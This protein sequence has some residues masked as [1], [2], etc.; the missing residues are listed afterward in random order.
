[1]DNLNKIFQN[2]FRTSVV[3][4]MTTFLPFGMNEDKVKHT[5][6]YNLSEQTNKITNSNYRKNQ[7]KEGSKSKT[8][9]KSNSNIDFN[10][11]TDL[12]SDS[13]IESKNKSYNSN[14]DTDSAIV[15]ITKTGKCYH[16][17]NRSSC[18]SHSEI[19][20]TLKKAIENKYEKCS[21][22]FD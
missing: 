2:I 11:K 14:A 5:Y 3:C 1:M 13:N 18:L 4:L 15:Y 9:L 20:I 12:K 21:K 19:P 17:D 7:C 10:T 16:R 22:C 6:T 8:D